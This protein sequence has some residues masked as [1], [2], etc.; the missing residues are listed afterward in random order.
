MLE[1]H[2]PEIHI[3]HSFTDDVDAKGA[4][5]PALVTNNVHWCHK[6]NFLTQ[7]L[8][9][10]LLVGKTSDKCF[11]T[12]STSL[13]LFLESAWPEKVP[14]TQKSSAKELLTLVVR[15]CSLGLQ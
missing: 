2:Q 15:N 12:Y 8:P 13:S 14:F 1:A 3:Q 11:S 9:I 6:S 5:V 4:L 10:K 7:F